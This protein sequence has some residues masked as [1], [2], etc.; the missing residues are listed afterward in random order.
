MDLVE[1]QSTSGSGGWV[2]VT[3]TPTAFNLLDLAGEISGT[4]ALTQVPAGRYHKVRLHIS[5]AVLTWNEPAPAFSTSFTVPPGH[6]DITP[7]P[8]IVIVAGQTT[9]VGPPRA[10]N[11]QITNPSA[12]VATSAMTTSRDAPRLRRRD[13]DASPG[14]RGIIGA[15]GSDRKGN[16]EVRGEV[17]GE[18][19]L[20]KQERRK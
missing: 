14:I 16:S 6:I 20:G 9:S 2:T 3:S 15:I 8:Q 13:G 19:Y 18:V 12:T 7:K 1:I 5:Q 10:M 17:G 11:F 4:V